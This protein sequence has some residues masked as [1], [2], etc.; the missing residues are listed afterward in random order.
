MTIKYMS[1]LFSL[2]QGLLINGCQSNSLTADLVLQNG[3]IYTIEKKNERY[4]AI[5]IKKDKIIDIGTI[6]D[7]KKYVGEIT[8]VIDLEGKTVIPGFI[9]SHAHFM[10]L[11]YSKLNLDLNN[12]KSWTELLEKVKT[13]INKNKP[14]T[15]I[16]GRGWHQ[17]KWDELP[18]TMIEGYPVHNELSI[19]SPNNP[20]Y[21]KHA[22]GHAILVNQ[23]AMDLAGI[24]KETIDPPGG[25][26]IRDKNN[27]PT[28]ILLEKANFTVNKIL[29]ESK[30]FRNDKE[31]EEINRK[32]Y[33]L[34]SKTCLEN[35]ITSFH[36]AGSTFEEIRF[37]YKMVGTKQASIRLWVMI[38]EENDSLKKHLPSYKILNFKDRLT[39]RAIKKYMDGALG[40]RGAWLLEPYSDLSSTYGLNDTPLT[41]LYETAQLALE[42]GFQMCIHAIGDRGNRETL[43]I[44]EEVT[45]NSQSPS[46]LRWRIEHA[47]HLHPDDIL[48]F[49]KLGIIAAIQSVHCTSDGPWVPKRLGE[50]RSAEGAYVWQKLLKSGIIICN[51]TD[52]PVEDINPIANIYAAVTRR[53]SDGS[54]FYPEQSLTRYQALRSYTIDAA[55]AG[56]EENIKGSLIPGKLADLTV[57]SKDIMTITEEDIRSI[58]ILYTIIGGK[59]LYKKNKS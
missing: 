6:P 18:G 56:F 44:Y 26:I 10:S 25:R 33:H 53:F 14:G 50:K 29:A 55:Y 36:D 31:V 21:L 23:F 16:E 37:F 17:E 4:E 28:G 27:C 52:A 9:D 32:T 20:I 24:S 1:L 13:T 39:V 2:Y 38:E 22:S 34:A 30:K 35:G 47:Q 45:K 59:I 51:G 41:E 7:I 58:E 48:S 40:V 49:K 46:D 15:W 5:A 57:L 8:T 42:H 54:A 43:N 3:H 11:G 12:V 19:I